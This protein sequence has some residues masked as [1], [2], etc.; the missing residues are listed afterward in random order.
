M[1]TSLIVSSMLNCRV[2]DEVH[3]MRKIVIDGSNTSGFQR[4]ALVAVDGHLEVN[5]RQIG[6]LSLCLEEDAAR[7]VETKDREV[8]Y[9]LDRLGI[10]L[11]EIAT[12]PDMYDPEEVKEV[13]QRLGSI[14]RSTAR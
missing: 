13:A 1:Q 10:P 12:A 11:I 5:G 7:K 14:L 8:T 4:T 2:M 3:F 9:R 6:I